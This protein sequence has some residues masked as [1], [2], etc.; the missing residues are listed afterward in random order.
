MPE[1]RMSPAALE[2]KFR[3]LAAAS[4][5]AEAA[6]ELLVQLRNI[7]DAPNNAAL[8]RCLGNI[9]IHN[10]RMAVAA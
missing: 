1:N 7:F 3:S 5:G 8:A 9:V 4:T 10:N 2:A 6:E